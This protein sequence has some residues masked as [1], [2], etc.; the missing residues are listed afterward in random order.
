MNTENNLSMI[1][2][3]IATIHDQATLFLEKK[4]EKAGLSGIS[5]SHGFILYHLT[6]SGKMTMSEIS[7][8]IGKNKS[9]TTVLINKLEK[10]GYIT[11]EKCTSDNRICF[12]QLSE[13]GKQFN[14]C[15]KEISSQ[16]TQT[17]YT[18]FTEHE[19]ETVFEL[20]T[21]IQTNLN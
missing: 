21:K 5:S 14:N 15:M 4:L 19:K 2:S 10:N 12:I 8:K 7:E 3:L 16:L 1:S 18:N 11:R 17:F 20:L 13:K 6:I 9:T